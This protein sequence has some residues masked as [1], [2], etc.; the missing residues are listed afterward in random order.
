MTW[1]ALCFGHCP[2]L[3]S[4][5]HGKEGFEGKGVELYL[6]QE[7]FKTPGEMSSER[8]WEEAGTWL[9]ASSTVIFAIWSSFS[10]LVFL[11]CM[12]EEGIGKKE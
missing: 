8:T 4:E 7:V 3:L 9:W 6:C 2:V 10:V 5:G 11:P 1:N 12:N